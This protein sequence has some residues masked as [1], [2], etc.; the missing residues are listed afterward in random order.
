MQADVRQIKIIVKYFLIQ[1]NLYYDHQAHG[2]IFILFPYSMYCKT[3]TL[4][5]LRLVCIFGGKGEISQIGKIFLF[6]RHPI[7]LQLL[8][9]YLF[10]IETTSIFKIS[11]LLLFLKTIARLILLIIC[12]IL[13]II[14]SFIILL[15]S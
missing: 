14:S 3:L 1:I 13:S 2:S 9:L 4:L 11:K 6:F 5:F 7:N 10:D 12:V 15:R 8:N